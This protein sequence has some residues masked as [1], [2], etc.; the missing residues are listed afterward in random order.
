MGRLPKDY[1]EIHMKMDRELFEWLED[2]CDN[3][4]FKYTEV[5]ETAVRFCLQS[6][7][8]LEELHLKKE[9]DIY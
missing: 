7:S 8:G 4:G 3:W 1:K 9:D 5:I 6:G 2:Y